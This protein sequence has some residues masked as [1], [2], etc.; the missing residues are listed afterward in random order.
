[1]PFNTSLAAPKALA[2]KAGSLYLL[3][4]VIG[5][6]AIAYVPSQIIISGDAV[7]TMAQMRARAGLFRLGIAGDMAVIAAE[8]A[9]T[10][11]LYFL[12]RP[13]DP[14]RAL[15]AAMARFGMV[16]VMSINLLINVA[17]FMMAQGTL[18]GTAEGM[19]V[20][21]DIHAQGV[22]LWGVL[23]GIH[24]FVLGGL[25]CQS[26]YFPKLLGG[27]LLVGAFG[28]LVEGAST[29]MGLEHV[30]LTWTTI[31]L[32]SLVTISELAYAFWL[33]I[34]GLNEEKWRA[35]A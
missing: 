1:M 10:A 4:A 25:I 29:L 22:Y 21:L 23:F 30:A 12:L 2:R 8:I 3:I 26:G 13:V 14:V 34:K 6:F 24:L 11:I 15:I 20:L 31:A 33:L 5:A 19:Q 35:A 16:M 9:L 32:L 7:A 27:G 18:S 17:A 28:Y